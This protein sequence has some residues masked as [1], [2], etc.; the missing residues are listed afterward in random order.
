METAEAWSSTPGL[1]SITAFTAF[2]R[3]A[4]GGNIIFTLGTI[5]AAG[6]GAAGFAKK[7]ASGEYP[8]L[9][10]TGGSGGGQP[11]N[12][13]P[14]APAGTGG[15]GA[16]FSL[17]RAKGMTGVPAGLKITLISFGNGGQGGGSCG[18]AGGTGGPGGM[19]HDNGM[20]AVFAIPSTAAAGSFFGGNG[21][22]GTP[23]G[24]GGVGGSDGEG[25]KIGL[26]GTTGTAC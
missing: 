20:R 1:R 17:Y 8:A 19:L 12:G 3:G 15:T 22:V 4:S 5:G 11:Q 16:S 21:S 25:Q 6:T 18:A 26:D 9:E 10:F 24:V 13:N 2:S 23:A 14:P 7:P